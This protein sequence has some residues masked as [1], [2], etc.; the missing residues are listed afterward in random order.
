MR[1]LHE[2]EREAPTRTTVGIGAGPRRPPPGCSTTRASTP[3]SWRAGP[4]P[5]NGGSGPGSWS[6]ARRRAR[7]AGAGSARTARACATTASNCASTTD[8]TASFP[9]LTGGRSVMVYAQTEVCKDLIAL[10]L[11]EGG[12][13]RSRRRR[14][15]WRRR[16]RLRVRFRQR[17]PRGRPGQR[18]VRRRLRWSGVAR[19]AIPAAAARVFEGPLR[20]AR[21]PRRPTALAPTSLSTPASRPRLRP[22]ASP[23][24]SR[25]YLQAAHGPSAEAW[26]DEEIWTSWSAA[27][28]PPATGQLRARPITQKSVTRCAPAASTSPR[29]HGPP[30]PRR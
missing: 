9:A 12:R 23:S 13:C 16:H 10:Q 1:D 25:L 19:K 7:A 8:A 28:R 30:L 4:A 20:L 27:S 17:G 15:P 5:T 6:R 26:S 29:R 22:P 21:H 2:P 11:Q 24:V 14:W 3:S 18:P